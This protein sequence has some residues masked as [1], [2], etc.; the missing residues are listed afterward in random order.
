MAVGISLFAAKRERERGVR[1][2]RTALPSEI[3]VW[4]GGAGSRDLSLPDGV[5]ALEDLDELE[6]KISLLAY[7]PEPG[8][9]H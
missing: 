1:D 8:T 7:R 3:T 9:E 2:L 5:E 6:R 4:V